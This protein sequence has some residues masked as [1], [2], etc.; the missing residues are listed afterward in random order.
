M[1]NLNVKEIEVELEGVRLAVTYAFVGEYRPATYEDPP[2]YPSLNI[3]SVCVKDSEMDI[4][5][6]LSKRQVEY[7]ENFIFANE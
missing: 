2:E 3:D 4:Y 5:E 7:V 1:K 6:L